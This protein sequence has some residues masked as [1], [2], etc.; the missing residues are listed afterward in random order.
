MPSIDYVTAQSIPTPEEIQLALQTV[1]YSKGPAIFREFTDSLIKKLGN[2]TLT[3]GWKAADFNDVR[4]QDKD[5]NKIGEVSKAG[6]KAQQIAKTED[7]FNNLLKV[8]SNSLYTVVYKAQLEPKSSVPEGL[9]RWLG[10]GPHIRSMNLKFTKMKTS[11]GKT[12]M[13]GGEETERK[14]VSHVDIGDIKYILMDET[15]QRAIYKNCQPALRS[16]VQYALKRVM[17]LD[18]KSSTRTVNRKSG[19][20]EKEIVSHRDQL[21]IDLDNLF[22][23]TKPGEGDGKKYKTN[24]LDVVLKTLFSEIETTPTFEK[25]EKSKAVKKT[26][27]VSGNPPK[28]RRGR[29]RNR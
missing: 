1:F 7:K 22:S 27:S 8:I 12:Y 24:Y 2:S 21:R 18:G 28:S 9:D 17:G 29:A 20:S 13:K 16:L 14:P 11:T 26:K 23:P 25:T 4:A 15:V 19:K 5:H 3:K 6:Y 10:L